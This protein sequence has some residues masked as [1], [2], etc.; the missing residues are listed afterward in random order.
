MFVAM[1]FRMLNI[2]G[3]DRRAPVPGRKSALEKALLKFADRTNEYIIYPAVGTEFDSWE[4]AYEY[5]NLYSWERGFGISCGK[6]RFSESRKLR[7]INNKD[8]YVLS[9]ELIC[10]CAVSVHVQLIHTLCV[11]GSWV[12]ANML[13]LRCRGN[14]LL[15]LQYPTRQGVRQ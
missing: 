6:R 8:K 13:S 11:M 9:L 4:E 1:L 5:Y 10:C 15:M 7:G 14:L 12:I 2:E 3:P